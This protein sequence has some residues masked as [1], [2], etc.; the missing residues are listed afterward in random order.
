M[1]KYKIF[2]S[3]TQT[4]Y[5]PS[6][7]RFIHPKLLT[8]KIIKIGDGLI[9]FAADMGILSLHLGKENTQGKGCIHTD[10]ENEPRSKGAI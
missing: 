7:T 5:V 1:L 9:K 4:K 6:F 10:K 8:L 3:D 2:L